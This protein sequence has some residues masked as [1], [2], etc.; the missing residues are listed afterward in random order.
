M[1]SVL[2]YFI[3]RNKCSKCN[4]AFIDNPL[5]DDL[6]IGCQYNLKPTKLPYLIG[7]DK[8]G[9]IVYTKHDESV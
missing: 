1:G 9:F 4:L 6:C 2:S 3:S 7:I 5:N 8:D